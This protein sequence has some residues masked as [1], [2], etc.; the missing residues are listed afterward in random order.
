ILFLIALMGWMPA[1]FDIAVWHSICTTEIQMTVGEI[2]M[3][4][5]TFFDF[6]ICYWATLIFSLAFLGLVSVSFS[7]TGIELSGNGVIFTAQL[8]EIYTNNIGSWAYL[9]VA[10]AALTTMISTTL[11]CLDAQP[12]V[13]EATT[14]LMF[15][16]LKKIQKSY[17]IWLTILSL[18]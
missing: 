10:I 9:I 2:I 4:K 11:T 14:G 15:P 6:K 18:G 5:I 8:L 13:M 7:R 16:S 17:W 12:R 3:L 1:P